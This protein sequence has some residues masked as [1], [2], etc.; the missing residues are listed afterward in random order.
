MKEVKV[1][2]GDAARTE[3]RTAWRVVKRLPDGFI[4]RSGV[5]FDSEDEARR[6]MMGLRDWYLNNGDVEGAERCEGSMFA[7]YPVEFDDPEI[8]WE[9]AE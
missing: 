5:L 2:D 8:D 3:K 6:C 4:V 9:A 1:A 7:V